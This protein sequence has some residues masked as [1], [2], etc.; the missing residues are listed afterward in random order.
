MAT[1]RITRIDHDLRVCVKAGRYKEYVLP[2]V[3]AVLEQGSPWR[4]RGPE[5]ERVSLEVLMHFHKARAGA[6]LRGKTP[7][8]RMHRRFYAEVMTAKLLAAG[9]DAF[10]TTEEIWAWYAKQ[11]QPV[12]GCLFPG[13]V[14][15]WPETA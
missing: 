4:F 5:A 9:G 10:V 7:A 8:W 12:Q 13:K 2:R 3:D 1:Y 6:V 14:E 11:P 15:R